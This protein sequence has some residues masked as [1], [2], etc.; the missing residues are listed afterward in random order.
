MRKMVVLLSGPISGVPLVE[1]RFGKV[2]RNLV[3]QGFQ[4]LNP[5]GL[6]AGLPERTYMDICCAYLRAADAVYM[7]EGWSRSEGAIAERALAAKLGLRIMGS[8]V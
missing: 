8:E 5:A 2:E 7:L 4:V 3:A 6:P 1:D